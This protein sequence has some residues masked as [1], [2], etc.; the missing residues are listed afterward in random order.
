M[1]TVH[2]EENIAAVVYSVNENRE[3]LIRSQLGLCYSITRKISRV[4]LGLK[5][6]YFRYTGR[7]AKLDIS[8]E[9]LETKPRTIFPRSFLQNVNGKGQ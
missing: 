5:S 4:D 2:T 8:D 1:C 7:N 6:L 9:P 3:M